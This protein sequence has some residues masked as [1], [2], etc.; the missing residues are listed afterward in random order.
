MRARP[1]ASPPGWPR[2]LGV[3]E[4]NW[5]NWWELLGNVDFC[6]L[7]RTS[8]RLIE[9]SRFDIY[10]YIIY[11]YIYTCIYIYMYI[12]ILCIY[13]YIYVYIYIHVYIY[14]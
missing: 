8:R 10:I 12:Y 6:W 3:G 7:K 2:C 14:I 4:L 13:I 5:W 11:I 1:G 9:I